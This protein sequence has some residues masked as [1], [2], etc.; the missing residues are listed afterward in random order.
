M[1]VPAL[2]APRPTDRALDAVGRASG[3]LEIARTLEPREGGRVEVGR[4]AGQLGQAR[5]EHLQDRL[6]G[7]ARRQSLGVGRKAGQVAVPS[8]RQGAGEAALELRGEVGKGRRVGR[9][10]SPPLALELLAARHGAPEVLQRLRRDQEGRLRRPAELLLG[11]AELLLAERRPVHLE[12]IL[13]VWR[14][15]ADVRPDEEQRR[16]RT[17]GPCL[18]DRARHGVEVVA[19][20]HPRDVPAVRGAALADVLGEAERRGARQRDAVVVVEDDQLPEPQ[21]AGQRARLGADS[22]HEIAVARQHVRMMIDDGMARTVEAGRQ[23]G[24][25]DRH[26]DGGSEPLAEWARRGLDAGREVALG[27][28]RGP[29]AEPPEAL[30]LLERQVVAG[31]VEQ[32][33][34]QH[35][36]VAR[37]Q[38]EPIA[39]RP[40]RARGTVLQEPRPEHVRHRG[41]AHRQTGMAGVGLLNR[42]GGEET[43]GVDRHRIERGRR[44]RAREGQ[45]LQVRGFGA[46]CQA[47]A[48]A[49]LARGAGR[50]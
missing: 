12:G 20:V 24:L 44:H 35:G 9:S 33:V 49:M 39:I 38:D 46:T 15:E 22:L 16:P 7:L 50:A 14:P 32:R 8:L 13:L 5:G 23:M 1:E 18:V 43:D 17:L 3:T 29:A 27:V 42:V 36:A 10:L 6:G 31:E 47:P 4:A 21:V 40:R 30:E 34:E 25:G 2:V 45:G 37:R 28:P 41:G 26:S 48:D 11:G 19:V